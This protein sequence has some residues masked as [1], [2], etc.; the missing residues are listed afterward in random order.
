M[1]VRAPHFLLLSEA[2][3]AQHSA[4]RA[5]QWRFVLEAMDGSSKVEAADSEPLTTGERLE[6]LAIVRGLEALDQPSRVTLVTASRYVSRGIRFGL[7][8]WRESDW[9]WERYGQMT[10]VKNNDLW[11]RIDQAMKIH[12]VECRALRF[13]SVDDL[14]AATLPEA[15]THRRTAS[16]RS[17]RF[18]APQAA[19]QGETIRRKT[20]RSAGWSPSLQAV[21]ARMFSYFR[22]LRPRWFHSSA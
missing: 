4:E 22:R 6:L 15:S 9:H 18:D 17:L 20:E 8:Q 19:V 10:P 7:D 3:V 5:G 14:S 12:Q 21:C 16:G 1:S 2:D 11:Q 13:E